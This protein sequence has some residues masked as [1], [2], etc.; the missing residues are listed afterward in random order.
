[1][2]DYLNHVTFFPRIRKKIKIKLTRDPKGHHPA[3]QIIK[4]LRNLEQHNEGRENRKTQQ[5]PTLM[6]KMNVVVHKNG[7][8]DVDHDS[9]ESSQQ[10]NEL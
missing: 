3:L 9:K 6:L 1:M 4:R 7:T 2:S 8:M 5:I 10:Q